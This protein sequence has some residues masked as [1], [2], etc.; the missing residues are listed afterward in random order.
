MFVDLVVYGAEMAPGQVYEESSGDRR[1]QPPVPEDSRGL[2][3]CRNGICFCFTCFFLLFQFVFVIRID[4]VNIDGPFGFCLQC[5]LTKPRDQCTT[6]GS[7]IY[8]TK[9]K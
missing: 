4:G 6:L 2:L 7:S 3:R 9:T 1:S 8:S 5:Y